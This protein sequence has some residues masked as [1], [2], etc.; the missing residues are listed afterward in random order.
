MTP[1]VA[2]RLYRFYRSSGLPRWH[3]IK[4]AVKTALN[5]N[6]HQLEGTRHDR[7]DRNTQRYRN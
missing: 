3:A 2:L 1:L 4:K 7:H 5:S 6:P